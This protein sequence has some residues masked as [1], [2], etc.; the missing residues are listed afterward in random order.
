MNRRGFL[1]AFC[2]GAPLIA[3]PSAALASQNTN[4]H[5]GRVHQGADW[6]RELVEIEAKRQGDLFPKKFHVA[7]WVAK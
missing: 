1:A 5:V 6:P 4:T 3:I 2:S 7:A